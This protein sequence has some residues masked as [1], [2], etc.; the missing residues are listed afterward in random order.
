MGS[1]VDTVKENPLLL[2]IPAAVAAPALFP[3]LAGGAGAAGAGAA[4]AAGTGL[5]GASLAGGAA[6]M[7]SYGPLAAAK[8]AGTGG[9]TAAQLAG[10]TTAGAGSFSL[11]GGV[12]PVWQGAPV[13]QWAYPSVASY[14][15]PLHTLKALG[16]G[17][18]Q[19]NSVLYPSIAQ[20]SIT[21]GLNPGSLAPVTPGNVLSVAEG[22]SPASGIGGWEGLMQ[23]TRSPMG[24]KLLSPEGLQQ[25]QNLFGGEE[26]QQA[27]PPAVTTPL[28]I[29]VPLPEGTL[30]AAAAGREF[31]TPP[32]FVRYADLLGESAP[33]PPMAF[34]A[35]PPWS[36]TPF[37]VPF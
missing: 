35:P 16:S 13:N 30:L 18:V 4:T 1:V 34:T 28:G 2:A 15:T 17:T 5:T 25:V 21:Q 6:G 14:N 36:P 26:D 27:L 19:P 9:L 32:P 8:M 3:A 22:V 10:S 11:G 20:S 31:P 12:P 7:G 37:G 24:R 29:D 33:P 23:L